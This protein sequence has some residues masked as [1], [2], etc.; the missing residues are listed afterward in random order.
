M[1]GKDDMLQ[2]IR[3]YFRME[4]LRDCDLSG[5]RVVVIWIEAIAEQKYEKILETSRGRFSL[6]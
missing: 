2:R 6:T 5:T 3:R 4:F 1:R